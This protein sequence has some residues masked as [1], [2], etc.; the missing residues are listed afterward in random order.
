MFLAGIELFFGII[1]A[2]FIFF[3]IQAILGG[4]WALVTTPT[5]PFAQKKTGSLSRPKSRNNL[6][7]WRYF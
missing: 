5:I 1:A 3:G 7:F 6:L 4:L 2:L